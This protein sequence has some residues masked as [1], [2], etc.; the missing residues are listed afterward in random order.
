MNKRPHA[1]RRRTTWPIVVLTAMLG[2]VGVAVPALAGERPGG[3]FPHCSRIDRLLVSG[4]ERQEA[5]CLTDL[6]TAGTTLSGHSDPTDWSGLV[7]PGTTNPSGVPGIQLDGYFPDTSTFNTTHGRNHDAQFVV[8]L[9]DDWNGGLVVAGP[10]GTRKQYANDAIIADWVL[11]KGYAFASTDKGNNGPTPHH[12]GIRPGDAVAEWNQRMTQLT[13]AA[14][15]VVHQRYGHQPRRTFI[16][17]VSAAGYLTRW[18]LENVPSL[19]DGGVDWEGLLFTKDANLLT[20]LPTALRDYP[21]YAAGDVAAHADM[22]AAGY[23][24]GSEP[25]WSFHY[26]NFWDPIQRIFREEFDPDFDGDLDAGVPRC[27][28]GTPNCD[29]DYDYA[30]RPPGVRQA[31]GRISLTGRIGKPLITLH[32]TLDAA[33]PP[34]LNSDVYA[35]LVRDN[36]RGQRFRYYT[37]V[38]GNH[39]DGLYAAFPQVVRPILPCHRAAFEALERWVDRGTPPPHSHPLPRPASGD[40]VNICAL[41]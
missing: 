19:Y 36:H 2:A 15:R 16:T 21:R 27:P 25:L 31:I 41:T 28:S 13:V 38:G 9:P 22:L 14:K 32:G 24:A 35:N 7:A 11:A 33:V 26:A 37:V 5:A 10:P 4:A 29:A 8:R 6:T 34:A 18:Q 30:S 23:P 20:Q 39:F 17:G 3:R 40:A 1:G 12:D